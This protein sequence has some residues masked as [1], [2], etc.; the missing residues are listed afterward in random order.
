MFLITVLLG[1]Y[2]GWNQ[3]VGGFVQDVH[4]DGWIARQGTTDF[5]NAASICPATSEPRWQRVPMSR[6]ST[7]SSCAQC[8]PA[9]R[10]RSS[11]RSSS[12]MTS[13]RVSAAHRRSRRAGDPQ[14][15]EI[16][17]DEVLSRVTGVGVGDELTS[18]ASTFK[19]VGLSSGGNLAF[20]QASFMSVDS[21]QKLLDMGDLVTFC[22]CSM[23]D[24][25]AWQRAGRPELPP[26]AD[27]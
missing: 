6:R 16:V 21:A 25:A 5:I 12:A 17:I 23:K 3:K 7:R 10:R 19:V 4:A 22:W 11:R 27:G 8:V 9:R 15:N 2:Q 18:G 20:T 1:L 24:R 13:H 26:D 14:G